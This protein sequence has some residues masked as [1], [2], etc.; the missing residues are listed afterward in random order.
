MPTSLRKDFFHLHEHCIVR[1]LGDRVAIWNALGHQE[2]SLSCRLQS[3]PIIIAAP[4]ARCCHCR[5]CR[6]HV[7][8]M[9]NEA[10]AVATSAPSSAAPT[11]P[12][13]PVIPST[14]PT[15]CVLTP[16]PTTH[17]LAQCAPS[18]VGLPTLPP[19]PKSYVFLADPDCIICRECCKRHYNFRWYSHCFMCHMKENTVSAKKI[20]PRGK[21][22]DIKMIVAQLFIIE[23]SSF[24]RHILLSPL[25]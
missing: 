3:S 4:L 2:I 21:K 22:T 6:C 15:P 18:A 16:V 13:A 20:A 1:G 23:D 24:F 14:S 17:D 10:N 12:A 11:L 8:T 19:W 25:Y 7:T 5:H 9:T